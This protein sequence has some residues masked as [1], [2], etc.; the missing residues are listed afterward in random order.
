MPRRDYVSCRWC[1]RHRNEVGPIS[2]TRAC[3]DCARVRL[4]ENVDGIH[5]HSGPAFLRWRLGMAASVLDAD[6]IEQ[7]LAMR[8]LDTEAG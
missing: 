5:F 4:L 8:G 3:G 6:L 2:H 7:V 1:G